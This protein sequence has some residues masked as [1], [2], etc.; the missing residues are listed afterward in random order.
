MG[1]VVLTRLRKLITALD[2][3]DTDLAARIARSDP[4]INDLYL[5]LEG[6]CIDLVALQQPVASDL[7]F[8]AASFKIITD[9]ERIG[10]LLRNFADYIVTR[11]RP[12]FAAIGLSDLAAEAA[13]AVEDALAAYASV[14]A[15][16]CFDIADGDDALDARC[17]QVT[18]DVIRT[19][20][21]HAPEDSGS[22]EPLLES[23]MR[24]LLTVRDIERIGDHA[25]N[26]AAR[27]LYMA[28]SDDTLIY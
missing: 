27:T 4:E 11:E 16:A 12:E 23:V 28:E 21:D 5:T 8:I 24:V 7:R 1:E 15:D 25:V 19:L 22:L 10:D 3:G 13:D 6:D 9:L 17:Q 2:S 20:V 18:Q 26:I 14:D